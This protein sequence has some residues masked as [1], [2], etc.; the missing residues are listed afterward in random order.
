[1]NSKKISQVNPL[2]TAKN[3][4]QGSFGWMTVL[5]IVVGWA[6]PGTGQVVAQP[7]RQ[8]QAEG[9]SPRYRRVVPFVER[10]INP[11][12]DF[13]EL[14]SRHDIVELVARD[15]AF[16]WAKDRTF[17]HDIWA[18]ELTFKP[19]SLMYVD[20]PGKDGKLRRKLIWYMVF[21]VKN[22]G[23]VF[24]AGETNYAD[25]DVSQQTDEFLGARFVDPKKKDLVPGKLQQVKVGEPVPFIPT[26]KL[27]SV[28]KGKLYLDRVIPAAVDLIRQREDPARPLKTTVEMTGEI[29]AST[30]EVDRSVWGVVTWEDVDP[31]TDRFSI[32][33]QGLTNAYKWYDTPEGRK[34]AYKTLRLD[35]WRPGDDLDEREEEIRFLRSQWLYLDKNLASPP[36][37]D[38]AQ[39]N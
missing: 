17:R 2:H 14:T 19:L 39:D 33:I 30:N 26:F 24:R 16:D 11:E 35:F 21:R 3:P 13:R 6:L 28:D 31:Q 18:V 29:P 4:L 15:P 12:R 23:V 27:Y 8:Q 9:P 32:Y 38:P 5:W 25:Q 1:M 10:T 37:D 7:N 20:L 34:Y 36:R 22:P